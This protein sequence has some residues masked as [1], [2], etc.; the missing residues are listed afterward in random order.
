M[1]LF[2]S[3]LVLND[4]TE[5]RTFS[6]RSQ[7]PDKKAIVG[8]YIED[9]AAI[10]A[11]SL[12]VV[13]HDL[14]GSVPRHLLQSTELAVPASATDGVR[15]KITVNITVTAHPDFTPAEVGKRFSLL[16]D[17]IAETGFLTGFMSSKL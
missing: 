1:A 2:T 5:N 15:K 4:G 13:K 7:K 10:A 12:L 14:S 11:E 6:F 9:A 17:A 3:P 16:T 8:D